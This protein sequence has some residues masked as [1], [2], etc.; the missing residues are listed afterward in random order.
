MRAEL[1]QRIVD[2]VVLGAVAP[3]EDLIMD[4]PL[5]FGG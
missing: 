3:G 2:D 5:Q 1:L 4:K